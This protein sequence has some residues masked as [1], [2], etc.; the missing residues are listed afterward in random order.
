M[1][2]CSRMQRG[3]PV[4]NANP[5][6][7]SRYEIVLQTRLG[8]RSARLFETFEQ[9]EIPGDGMI[10]RGHLADQ[11]ALHGVLGRIRDL[12]VTLVAVRVL[13]EAPAHEGR[14]ASRD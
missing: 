9:E 8:G 10:L 11:A 3:E 2:Y 12:G 1:A 14:P 13:D 6:A 7:G 4:T 5:A